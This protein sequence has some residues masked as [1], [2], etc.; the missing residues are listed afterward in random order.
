M[1]WRETL[2]LRPWLATLH[3]LLAELVPDLR[4]VLAFIGLSLLAVGVWMIYP[5]AAFILVG[6]VLF[7]IGVFG[8]PR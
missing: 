1:R 5:P 6:A 4:D 3:A 7:L 8:I 2:P